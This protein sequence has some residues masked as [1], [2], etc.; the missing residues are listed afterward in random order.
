MLHL[1]HPSPGP[2]W[3]PDLTF[4][5]PASHLFQ[6]HLYIPSQ[7]TDDAGPLLRGLCWPHGS[8]QSSL[9]P[10]RTLAS[11]SEA[12]VSCRNSFSL[13]HM[14]CSGDMWQSAANLLPRLCPT[15]P[16]KCIQCFPG[17]RQ[18][19][20][21]FYGSSHFDLNLPKEISTVLVL[22]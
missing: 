15:H 16:L 22:I 12:R 11:V 5:P 8:C 13:C 6:S 17:T 21:S 9:P 10:A 19:E 7:H 2:E 4:I 18:G 20:K 3:A 1:P 14:S